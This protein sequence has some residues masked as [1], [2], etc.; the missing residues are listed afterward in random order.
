MPAP[1]DLH[2]RSL[3]EETTGHPLV[4]LHGLLGSSR[5]WL[6]VARD[7]ASRRPVHLLDLRNHGESPH[8]PDLS[9]EALVADL[10]HWCE[11]HGLDRPHLLG[12]SLGGKV[13]MRAAV[14][15]RDRFEKLVVVDI[16]PRAYRPHRAELEAMASLDLETLASRAEAEAHLAR[17]FD[18]PE[19]VQF[20]LTNLTR[21]EGGGFRW[22]CHLEAL[23]D[24]A[25]SLAGDPLPP[26]A[27]NSEPVLFIVGGDSPYVSEEDRERLRDP[28][29][30]A[31]VVTL[32]GSGHNPH[33]QKRA[34]FVQVLESYLA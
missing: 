22:R 26:G 8:H 29:P 28:F 19:H 18:D 17:E 16:A 31:R 9:F 3:G 30:R 27:R 11:T 1:V 23:L 7:L 13:A 4:I 20:L 10:L 12:H 34:E 5:N 33:Y 21:G 14:E 24:G 32:K 6:S 15:H 25:E 2:A